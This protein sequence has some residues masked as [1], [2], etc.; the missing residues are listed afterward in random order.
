MGEEER[1]GSRGERRRGMGR[2][3]RGQQVGAKMRKLNGR[4]MKMIWNRRK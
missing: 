3:G 1:E 4:R 2:E